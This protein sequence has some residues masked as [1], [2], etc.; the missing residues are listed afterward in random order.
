[1]VAVLAEGAVRGGHEV[2]VVCADAGQAGG[3]GEGGELRNGVRVVRVPMLGVLW[4]QPLAPGY[5]IAARW[6]ADVVYVHRPHPLADVASVFTRAKAMVVFHHSDMVRQR[7]VR[8]IYR[9]MAR[10]VAARAQAAVVTSETNLAQASDLGRIG[11]SR[12]HVIHLG[13]DAGV[14]R[15]DPKAPRP[16]VFPDP[17]EGPVGLFVGRLVGYK[18]LDVLLDAVAGSSL[19]VVIVGD[20]PLAPKLA[21]VVADRSLRDRVVLAGFVPPSELPVYHQTADYFVLPSTTPAEMF[22]VSMIEAMACGKPVISTDL[23]TGVRDVNI[24][25]VT[26]IRV[27][28]G[29]APA[30]R[31]AMERL[32]ADGQLR[33]S[34]GEAGRRRVEERFTVQRM[35]AAHIELCDRLVNAG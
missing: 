29:E 10:W 27:P 4:S 7:A 19:R 32:D 30:L 21:A 33:N 22:G 12:A 23:P 14:F 9:P 16:A 26:G 8:A 2:R 13:V 3:A 5:L 25:G 28:P 34:L 18:G 15:P 1:M 17:V 20:G 35:V 11:G 31:A 6:P 24:D